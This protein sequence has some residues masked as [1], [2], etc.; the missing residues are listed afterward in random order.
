[1]C[2]AAIFEQGALIQSDES[3]GC[4]NQEA[5]QILAI[6]RHKVLVERTPFALRGGGTWIG[7]PRVRRRSHG[8]TSACHH[9]LGV[10][11]G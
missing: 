6:P 10:G 8:S 4:S 7:S 5:H 2:W 1:M 9:G 11:S 3:D